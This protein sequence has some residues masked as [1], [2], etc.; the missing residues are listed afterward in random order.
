M[1]SSRPAKNQFIFRYTPR[2]PRR[3]GRIAGVITTNVIS[4][5]SCCCLLLQSSAE[6][7]ESVAQRGRTLGRIATA[8]LKWSID[9]AVLSCLKRPGRLILYAPAQCLRAHCAGFGTS[10]V[11][12]APKPALS[13]RATPPLDRYCHTGISR[14]A[15]NTRS[16][17]CVS[18]RAVGRATHNEASDS[19]RRSV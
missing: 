3:R 13:C 4:E 11:P 5:R 12:P 15:S 8:R 16:R 14:A 6:V 10:G 19:R 1:R 18:S 9:K 17:C 7:P 2:Y